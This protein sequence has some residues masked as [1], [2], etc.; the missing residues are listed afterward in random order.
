MLSYLVT[1]SRRRRFEQSINATAEAEQLFQ[2]VLTCAPKRGSTGRTST[3]P[4]IADFVI[5]DDS[6]EVC[7]EAH[8]EGIKAFHIW[9]PRQEWSLE[10]VAWDYDLLAHHS[11]ILSW[12][13]AVEKTGS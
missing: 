9:L 8:R 1:D 4:A 6:A 3:I 7:S 10:G 5:I 12:A 2:G 13:T 11:G